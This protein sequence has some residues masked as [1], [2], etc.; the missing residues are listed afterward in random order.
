MISKNKTNRGFSLVE[1]LL[2]LF[3]SL[4]IVLF[5][6][7]F[8]ITSRKHFLKLRDEQQTNEAGYAAL[9]K[10]RF[11]ILEAGLGLVSPLRQ[12]ILKAVNIEN[13]IL[14]IFR[15][16]EELIISSDLI[17]GQTRILLDSLKKVKR[18][19]KICIFDLTKGE[20]KSVLSVGQN[21]LI[22][23]S[24]L[25]FSYSQHETSL[26]LLKEISF[27]LDTS[28]HILRRKV[29]SSPAQPLLEEASLFKCDY[30]KEANLV[31]L[32]LHLFS[33]EEQSYESLV[34]PKNL[35]LALNE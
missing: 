19:S 28:H 34:F 33:K 24:P 9:D 7:E 11:D 1:S 31:K 25:V 26:I 2:S 27:Y 3:L 4:I 32:T 35:A 30:D 22:F 14:T 21:S 13:D 6:L 8:L 16:E 5:S 23:S 12:G 15:A 17:A 18:G 29:N 10:I 20:M